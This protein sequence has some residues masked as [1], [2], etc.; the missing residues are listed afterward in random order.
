MANVAAHVSSARG[1]EREFGITA[2]RRS[3]GDLTETTP[4]TLLMARIQ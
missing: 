1:D 4:D 2:A 3:C